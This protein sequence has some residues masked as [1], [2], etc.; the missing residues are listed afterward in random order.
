[1]TR[2]LTP[3]ESVHPAERRRWT[4]L[5]RQ[6]AAA[7]YLF[8][9]PFLVFFIVF[10]ARAVVQSVYM[11]LFNWQILQPVHPF[12]GLGNYQE[13]LNDA[14]WWTSLRNTFTFAFVTV[15]G[16]S[17]LALLCALM[18]NQPVRGRTFFRAL[19]YA[20]NLLSVSVVGI[21]WGWLMDSQ[22]GILNYALRLIG[23]PRINWLGDA[24]IIL[25][26]LSIAT[27][28]WTFGFPM[29]IFL[30]GLQTI[31][32]ILYEASRIDGASRWQSF[33]YITLPLLRPTILFVTVT[34]FISH[35]QVFGQ[36]YIMPTGGAG[37]PGTASYTV[38]IYLYQ[39]AWRYYRM[40]YGSAIAVGL[41][42][43]M[44]IFTLIQFRFFGREV[45]Y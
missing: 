44:V 8:L 13:L 27:I 4:P 14:L 35:F 39:T 28:W 22:F 11:S 15:L 20:P 3:A 29:L 24:N 21:V 10:V 23:L 19:F 32:D 42:V 6:Q 33:R 40:G 2:V 7:G 37:G 5:R 38:I 17:L 34:G 1:M 12:I 45:K 41:T 18:V 30:A 43:V 16:A 36:P 25:G 26:S 31:P 9:A